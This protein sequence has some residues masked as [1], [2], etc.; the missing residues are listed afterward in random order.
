M[1]RT[2]AF[3]EPVPPVAL[4]AYVVSAVGSGAAVLAGGAAPQ[5][6]PTFTRRIGAGPARRR[7]RTSSS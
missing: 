7:H 1:A 3:P 5:A 2:V 4:P 6:R